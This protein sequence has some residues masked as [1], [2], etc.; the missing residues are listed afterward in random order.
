MQ[1]QS[2]R[3]NTRIATT[4]IFFSNG[5]GIG[6]WAAS[7]PHFR[8]KL[9]VDDGRLSLALLGVAFGA[10]I[11]MP[12]AGRCVARIGSGVQI[13]IASIV[14]ALV[15]ALVPLAQ[16]LPEL[17]ACALVLGA[18]NGFLD[19]SINAHAS[20]LEKDGARAIMSSFHASFSIGAA[21]G[22]A[23]AA[24][25]AIAMLRVDVLDVAAALSLAIAFG[26]WIWIGRGERSKAPSAF[27]FPRGAAVP[28]AIAALLGML[29]EGATSD[30]SGVYLATVVHT[31]ARF[32]AV[33][34]G[35]FSIAMVAG[36]LIGDRCV[37]AFG[38]RLM[39][40]GGAMLATI[41][42]ATTAL[43]PNT[44]VAVVAFA[45]IGLGV[46]NIV[47][48]LYSASGRNGSASAIAMTAT[49]GYVGFLTGPPIV[50]GLSTL[51]NLRV[52]FALLA[53]FA[54]IVAT[55]G[56]TAKKSRAKAAAT[57]RE[58]HYGIVGSGT[59]LN[60]LGYGR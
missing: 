3:T 1:H 4:A 47:P 6:A 21:A 30:W 18:A 24:L 2:S 52:S 28:L 45:C 36:R 38:D 25:L 11:A 27:A 9:H 32:V 54:A 39:V 8:E 13:R 50:G 34:Y 19:I 5:L 10:A 15:L 43:L 53:V 60:D 16:N 14:F 20:D 35:A 26:S 42:F 12:I 44:P 40:R 46:A 55:I 58:R 17:I 59:D 48:I 56:V 51:T 31:P 29:C 7:I 33:G 41:G 23:L 57:S 37:R 22:A 49:A